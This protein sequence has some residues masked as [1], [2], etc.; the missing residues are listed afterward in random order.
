[1]TK[2]ASCGPSRKRAVSR[3]AHRCRAARASD[4]RAPRGNRPRK[5]RTAR[6]ADRRNEAR[7]RAWAAPRQRKPARRPGG[8][9]PAECS[10]ATYREIVAKSVPVRLKT[11][12]HEMDAQ[13]LEATGRFKAG[14]SSKILR[15]ARLP[16]ASAA[17]ARLQPQEASSL[18]K[19]RAAPC[20]PAPFD[21]PPGPPV[22]P[23]VA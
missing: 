9:A 11:A 6:S 22:S 8:R 2:G 10:S 19:E 21:Q 23:A 20:R 15:R 16:S 17:S 1:M 7:G 18:G 12:P 14:V 3:K 13:S 4:A 5:R